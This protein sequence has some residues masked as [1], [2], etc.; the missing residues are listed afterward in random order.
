MVML[1]SKPP[2]TC[3][4]VCLNGQRSALPDVAAKVELFAAWVGTP[5]VLM[6]DLIKSRNKKDKLCKMFETRDISLIQPSS[7]SHPHITSVVPLKVSFV[8]ALEYCFS[9]RKLGLTYMT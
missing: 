9:N 4:C 1:Q 6:T 8:H 5:A 2:G 7:Y 3:V